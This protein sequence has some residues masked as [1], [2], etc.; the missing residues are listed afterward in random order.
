MKEVTSKGVG[1]VR[2]PAMTIP[3]GHS[4]AS[5]KTDIEM[6]ASP[7]VT[8]IGE[9]ELFRFMEIQLRNEAGV[10]IDARTLSWYK[11]GTIPGALNYPFALFAKPADDPSWDEILPA[12]GV[13]PAQESGVIEQVLEH[14]GLADE[15]MTF[16]QWDFSE[17]KD[18]VLF[19]NG[20]AC[21]QSPRAIKGLRAVGYPAEKLFYY[22]GGMQ[23]WGL[24]GLTTVVP[25]R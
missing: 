25:G 11:K 7:G 5:S 23:L 12:L 10:L 3:T 22:R 15:K 1:R 2:K 9:V 20:P 4:R 24:W 21:D 13:V 14:L 16:G 17:A 8:T 19:C 6:E 18:L